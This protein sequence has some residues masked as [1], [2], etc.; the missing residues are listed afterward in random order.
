MPNKDL[1]TQLVL[2]LGEYLE[3]LKFLQKYGREAFLYD[4][5]IEVQV[6]RLMQLAIECSIDLGEELLS[7]LKAGIPKTYRETFLLLCRNKIIDYDLMKAM[8]LLA[9]FRNELVHDYLYLGPEKIYDKFIITPKI[10]MEY[11][12]AVKKFLK[13]F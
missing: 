12:Q 4:W 11:L 13:K 3:K 2:K 5:Q 8:Q 10:I 7:G 1:L 9:D 6:D